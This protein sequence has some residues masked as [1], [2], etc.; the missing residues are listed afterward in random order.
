MSSSYHCISLNV[1]GLFTILSILHLI[2]ALSRDLP[3]PT[4]PFHPHKR[5]II[6]IRLIE[7]LPPLIFLFKKFF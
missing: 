2:N 5:G 3:Y 4:I 6:A 7:I 1:K